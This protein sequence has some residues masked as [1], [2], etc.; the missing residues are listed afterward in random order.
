M[1]DE[2]GDVIARRPLQP[3]YELWEDAAAMAEFDSSRLWGDYGYDEQRHC[4]WANDLTGCRYRF[5]IEQIVAEEI[6]A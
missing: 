6:A 5:V 3:Q 1:L 4:W 2:N